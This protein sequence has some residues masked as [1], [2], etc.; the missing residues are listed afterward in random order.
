M[1]MV[2]TF[3]VTASCGMV[4]LGAVSAHAMRGANKIAANKIAANKIAANKIAANGINLNTFTTTIPSDNAL[5]TH[6]SEG[7]PFHSLSQ[8]GLGKQ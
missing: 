7:L 2:K 4:L 6:P 1:A 5:G 3:L 8:S